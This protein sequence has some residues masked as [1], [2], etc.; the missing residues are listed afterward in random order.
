MIARSE[1]SVAART[2]FGE[3]AG[4]APSV[5]LADL[6]LDRGPEA[7]DGRQPVGTR[8]GGRSAASRPASGGGLDL[9]GAVAAA[10]RRRRAR[11]R[12]PIRVARPAWRRGLPRR[13]RCRRRGRRSRSRTSIDQTCVVRHVVRFLGVSGHGLRIE[14]AEARTALRSHRWARQAPFSTSSEG[15]AQLRRRRRHADARGLH[16]RDLVFRAALAARDDRAGVAH[17][18]ARRRGAAGDEADHG[19]LDRL[20]FLMNSA[21]SSSA[22]P[23]IS[24]IMMI[25][26]VAGSVRNMS[27]MSMNSVPFTGS[28][29][30]PTAVDWPRPTFVVWNTAS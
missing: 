13:R 9:V 2:D 6:G 27:S 19:L 24:P 26:S 18:A 30:M 8:A 23:P 28:P 10:R 4:A 25:D 14:G 15:F 29:P 17:A 20:E 11:R 3:A 7:V 12:R 5:T 22:E 16:R 1:S 21:A